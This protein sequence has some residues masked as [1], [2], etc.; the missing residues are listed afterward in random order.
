[1]DDAWSTAPY[2]GRAQT[3][4]LLV[5]VEIALARESAELCL[6]NCD[7]EG[8]RLIHLIADVIDAREDILG[9]TSP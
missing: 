4:E 9:E 6:A 2:A 3:A 1:M 7:E 5:G 8:E